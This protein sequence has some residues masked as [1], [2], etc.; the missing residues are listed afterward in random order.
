MATA[1]EPANTCNWGPVMLVVI[2][3]HDDLARRLQSE[4]RS[5]NVSVENLAITILDDAVPV[6]GG[7]ADWG[8]RNKRRLE[9]IRKSTR[10]ELMDHEQ[11]ELDELQSA[12]D[13][14]FESFDRGLFAQLDEMKQTVAELRA[15]QSHE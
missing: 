3:V 6:S 4:A 8:K 1:N 9:L 12:L 10:S 15:E 7:D 5:R 14:R 13:E 2:S 11:A